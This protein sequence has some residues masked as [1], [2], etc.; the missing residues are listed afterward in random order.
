VC[1]LFKLAFFFLMFLSVTSITA[2]SELPELKT[3]GVVVSVQ[4]SVKY[5]A[6]GVWTA[7]VA[8]TSTTDPPAGFDAF[9]LDAETVRNDQHIT[10][11]LRARQKSKPS[12]SQSD[13]VMTWT[14]TDLGSHY[15]SIAVKTT[16]TVKTLNVRKLEDGMIKQIAQDSGSKIVKS[17]R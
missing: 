9:D 10:Q 16:T 1:K 13:L 3:G 4:S 5:P 15:V 12:S 6:R 8:L 11:V 7:L 2:Q 14:F 17:N